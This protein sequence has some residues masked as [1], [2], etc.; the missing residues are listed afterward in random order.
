M[1]ERALGGGYLQRLLAG[2]GTGAVARAQPAGPTARAPYPR[3]SLPGHW[4]HPVTTRPMG[5]DATPAAT[6][7]ASGAPI[8]QRAATRTAGHGP[9]DPA[10]L[11]SSVARS[12]VAPPR[13]NLRARDPDSFAPGAYV[14]EDRSTQLEPPP[15]RQHARELEARSEPERRDVTAGARPEQTRPEQTRPA[16]ADTSRS[17]ATPFAAAPV[18]TAQIARLPAE[19]RSITARAPQPRAP[20]ARRRPSIE[21]GTIEVHVAAPAPKPAPPPRLPVVPPAAP[22]PPRAAARISRSAAIF[23]L[24]QS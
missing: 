6:A 1:A 22:P 15:R 2:A 14:V 24:A 20:E 5:R 3:T 17:P 7:A 11:P 16:I 8:M 23:G 21:I 13:G 4:E 18:R 12:G 19:I 10:R 9:A